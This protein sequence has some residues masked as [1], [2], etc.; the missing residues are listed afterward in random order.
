MCMTLSDCQPDNGHALWKRKK[1][2]DDD[3]NQKN[4]A[5]CRGVRADTPIPTNA[6]MD[7]PGLSRVGDFGRQDAMPTQCGTASCWP[8][9]PGLASTAALER[10]AASRAKAPVGPRAGL[11]SLL[12]G[13]AAAELLDLLGQL[14]GLGEP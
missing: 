1:P 5:S 11:E 2:V 9:P 8:V 12:F 13:Q 14:P 7:R 4:S 10:P 6:L 3:P